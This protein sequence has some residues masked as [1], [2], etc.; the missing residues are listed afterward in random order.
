MARPPRAPAIALREG[1]APSAV[2]LP[3]MRRPPWS[4]LLDFLDHRMPAV[5]RAV[6]LQRM[7]DGEVLDDTGQPLPPHTPYRGG[8]RAWVIHR[9]S[10]GRSW[11][12]IVHLDGLALR[13]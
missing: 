11:D 3:N 4:T 13:V 2:A 9:W 7:A 10:S 1:V 6:W 12:A 5:G 8:L